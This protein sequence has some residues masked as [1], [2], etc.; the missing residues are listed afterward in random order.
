[1]RH[2]CRLRFSRLRVFGRDVVKALRVPVVLAP[3]SGGRSQ[4]GAPGRDRTSTPCGTRF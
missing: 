3:A 4:F 2:Q 1:M